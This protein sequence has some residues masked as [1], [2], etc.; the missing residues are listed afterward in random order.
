MRT[1]RE[2]CMGCRFARCAGRCVCRVDGRDVEEH[3]AA[4]DCPNGY[5]SGVSPPMP[6]VRPA[7]PQGV[8]R[9]A[10]VK[11]ICETCPERRGWVNEAAVLCAAHPCC[12]GGPGTVSFT[13]GRCEKWKDAT[14]SLE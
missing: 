11:P 6:H 9:A 14:A 3:A 12:G 1:A 5:H 7:T 10:A 8:A 4:E 13:N 2:V